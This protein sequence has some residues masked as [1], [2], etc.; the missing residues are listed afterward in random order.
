MAD[1]SK[2]SAEAPEEGFV[3]RFFGDLPTLVLAVAVALL[4]RTFF[5]QSFYVPSD[6]MFP[7]MLVGDH[8]FVNKLVYGLKLPFSD[9]RVLPLREPRRGE[10]IVFQ[11]GRGPRNEL[12]PADLWPDFQRDAFVKR[13]IAVPGDTVAVESGRIRLNGELLP[14]EETGETFT[15]AS[16]NEFDIEIETLGDCRHRVLNLPGKADLDMPERTIKPGRYFF[17]GDNR[18]NS[19]DG[20][21]FGTVRVEEMEGPAGLLYWSWDWSGGWLELLNPLTWID[22]LVNHT[23]WSRKGRFRECFDPL[24]PLPPSPRSNAG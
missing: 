18:D 7:T 11:L 17:M 4:I 21:L 9:G 6:S 14:L 5:F 13:L 20:R 10:V 1:E 2:A 15:D 12:R 22:N 8:V 16:G 19:H 3:Q 23:R 24:A